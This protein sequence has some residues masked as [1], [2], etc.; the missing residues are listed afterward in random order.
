MCSS[1][2][3]RAGEVLVI[4]ALLYILMHIGQKS[5]QVNLFPKW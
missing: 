1:I 4:S 2:I 5:L 3:Q